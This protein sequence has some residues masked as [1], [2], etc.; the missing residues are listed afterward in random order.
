M[1]GSVFIS[2]PDGRACREQF[3]VLK[4][5]FHAAPLIEGEQHLADVADDAAWLRKYRDGR[6]A[7]ETA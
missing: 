2:G 3:S 4:A 6:P 7:E 5:V 1:R